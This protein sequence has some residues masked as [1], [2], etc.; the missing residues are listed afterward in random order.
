MDLT[1]DGER[2]IVKNYNYGKEPTMQSKYIKMLS[3]EQR[4]CRACEYEESPHEGPSDDLRYFNE[5][6]Y[7]PSCHEEVNRLIQTFN[8]DNVPREKAILV[9]ERLGINLEI[10]SVN[11]VSAV[12]LAKK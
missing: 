2:R 7:H 10:L 1:N 6:V 9:F 3:D 4:I 11:G 5:G 12:K 8:E